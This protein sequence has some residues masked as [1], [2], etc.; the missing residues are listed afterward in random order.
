MPRGCTSAHAPRLRRRGQTNAD[1]RVFFLL[2]FPSPMPQ[3]RNATLSS[4]QMPS[5]SIIAIPSFAV[6]QSKK[7]RRA[8]GL[9]PFDNVQDGQVGSSAQQ[10]TVAALPLRSLF[11]AAPL[12]CSIAP[13]CVDS[14]LQ[15]RP[16]AHRERVALSTMQRS[17]SK[18]EP[19]STPLEIEIRWA[20]VPLL[21]FVPR[22]LVA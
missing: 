1:Q 18:G 12:L 19:C 15:L 9:L 3:C 4:L 13:L 8:Q 2:P 14:A 6:R 7:A 5:L 20:V 21:P 10:H 16:S 17:S 11:S 22:R